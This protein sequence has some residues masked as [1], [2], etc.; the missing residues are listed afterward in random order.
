MRGSAMSWLPGATERKL[1]SD[2]LEDPVTSAIVGSLVKSRDEK[3][4]LPELR[5]LAEQLLR[6]AEVPK[7]LDEEGVQLY[8]KKLE[9]AGIVEKEDGMYRLTPR[10]MDIAEVLRVS[11][12]PSR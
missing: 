11:P 4:S 12:P 2:V 9:N 1:V 5:Q 8:L 10:W 3:L 6:D 7:E